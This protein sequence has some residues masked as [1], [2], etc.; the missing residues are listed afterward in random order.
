[1]TADL[2]R[3]SAIDVPGGSGEDQTFPRCFSRILV[4]KRRHLPSVFMRR[5]ALFFVCFAG[6]PLRGLIVLA[7]AWVLVGLSGDAVAGPDPAK[8]KAASESFEAGAKAFGAEKFEE[9]AAHFEAAD[10]AAPSSKA[11]R[12]AIKAREKA[13]QA[14]RAA[15][16]AALAKERYPDDAETKKVADKALNDL[17]LKLHRVEVTCAS[18]C[19]LAVGS[20]IVHGEAA[21]RWVVFLDPGKITIGASFTSGVTATDQTVNA[22]AGGSSSVRFTPAAEKGTGGDTVVA[23]TGGAGG[24]TS[25]GGEGGEG[26]VGTG[27]PE[28]PTKKEWRIHPAFLFVCLAITAGAGATT[29]WS[30][31]DTINDPGTDA[32]RAGCAG[33]GEECQLYKDAQAKEVRTNA[34]IGATA[35]AGAI[36]VILGAVAKWSSD[37]KS[38]PKKDGGDDES[39]VIFDVPML[40]VGEANAKG[41]PS[42]YLRV[43]GR[44]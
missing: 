10:A 3:R 21:G 20:R 5:A 1:V 18:P 8:L 22:T 38:T 40:W 41:S 6:K 13:G 34:L 28:E 27:E 11:V 26:G 30:G 19:L 2:L 35:G 25:A 29:I 7:L 15:T 36:T 33:Q 44:F 23:P 42:V 31:I 43:G 12:L 17:G 14:S 24:D 39:A 9:A 16:L 4:D 32:V 37:E